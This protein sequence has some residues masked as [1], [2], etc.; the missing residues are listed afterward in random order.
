MVLKLRGDM[1]GRAALRRMHYKGAKGK[2]AR[3]LPESEKRLIVTGTGLKVK[4]VG[5]EWG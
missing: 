4:Q 3:K 2:W 5:I 1:I